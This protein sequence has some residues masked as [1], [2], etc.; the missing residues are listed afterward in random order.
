MSR[1]DS[2]KKR[3]RWNLDKFHRSHIMEIKTKDTSIFKT[4]MNLNNPV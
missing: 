3:Y 4:F 2:K 1:R